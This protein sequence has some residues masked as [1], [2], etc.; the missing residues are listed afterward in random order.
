MGRQV[1]IFVVSIQE[2]DLLYAAL[3]KSSTMKHLLPLV[4]L[5][6]VSQALA[7]GTLR[8]SVL[9]EQTKEP[10][11]GA[12]VLLAGTGFN[13][14]AG[15]DG[16][17][18]IKNLPAAPY[19][20]TCQYLGY[21]SATQNV[22]INSQGV[23]NI[24]LALQEKKNQ[25]EEVVVT[26]VLNTESD[27][28]VRKL[29]QNASQVVNLVSARTIEVSPDLTV[30]NVIQRVS[31]V[32]IERNSNG[33]GQYAIL[34]G[35]DKRYNYTLVNGIKIP[36]PDNKYRYVPLDLFP[37][38][39][40]G[41]LEVYKSLTPDLEGDA[42]GGVVNIVMKDAPGEKMF[43]I[44]L[45][46]GY[47]ELFMNRPFV[48]FE[49]SGV[50][51]KSPYETGGGNAYYATP[52]DFPKGTISYKYQSPIP[53]LVGNISVGNRYFGNRLGVV[54]AAS[55]QNT[56]RGSNSAFFS[57]N[58]YDIE[59]TSRITSLSERQFSERQARLGLHSKIDFRLS[60]KSKFQWYN[61]LM[62][63]RNEQ[64]R[65][66]KETNFSSGYDTTAGHD[67][68]PNASLTYT[69][70]SRLTQQ[71]I[72]NSTLQ[73]THLFAEALK[74][75]WSAVYSK[76]TNYVP[77]NA[78]ASVFGVRKDFVETQT[79]PSGMTR[80]WDH[81]SDRDLAAYL[82]LTY[83]QDIGESHLELSVGGLYRDKY[84]D[85]FYNN[86]TFSPANA[87]AQYGKDYTNFSEI[88]W[89]LNNPQ[90]AV[91]SS[92]TYT[93]SEKTAAAYLMGKL[94]TA[95]L[96]LIGGL[97]AE[98]TD[99]GYQMRFPL[100]EKRPSGSQVYTD[101][102]PSLNLKYSPKE[103]TNLR[104]SYFRSLNRPGFAELVPGPRPPT[105]E[106]IERGN[107]DLKRAIADNLDLRY[108]L[109]P[110]RTDQFM[111][112]IFYKYL[113]DPIEFTLQP[114]DT[115]QQDI[116]YIPGNFG[117]ATNYGFELDFIKYIRN[118]GIKANYTFTQSSITTQK[119]IRIR[120]EKG[121][122]KTINTDQTRP[123]Y[124]QS[125]HIANLS[126]LYKDSKSGWD[127]QLAGSYTGERI[128]IVAQFK[129]NDLWQAPF[130]QVDASAEKKIGSHWVVF[131]KANN[132]LDNPLKVFI[133]G[134]NLKNNNIPEQDEATGQTLIRRDYYQRSYLL[135]I[136]YKL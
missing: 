110:T 89:A 105:E 40:I 47:N 79:T 134:T 115:R 119:S 2:Q 126:L 83:L 111:A 60:D 96:Q 23:V 56:Y 9:D 84:R 94:N 64:I 37:S 43:K 12:V 57:S 49:A 53:N 29:E 66:A 73:G 116:Y 92:Q 15:L 35:M 112:G 32:S 123:L 21:E 33:D 132:L 91:A 7:Q 88:S 93:A 87:Q 69:T 59:A 48:S 62:S 114:D 24:S 25:L 55:F 50:N 98:H 133:K 99:Q 36:S 102:L 19:S 46:G 3:E 109:F 122:Q 121:E 5:L 45:S 90:G 86:Y 104:A 51:F 44:N 11:I 4:F 118:F 120:D 26:G 81:N 30:A 113:Q 95:N 71:Q 130:V 129:D 22:I 74:F 42:V 61:A 97:R 31:G 54:V 18:V 101:L 82:N 39:L 117:N 1:F 78:S 136:R 70:R 131:A 76:A 13:A 67:P 52:R 27:A 16:S 8:G 10:L 72:F 125:Q 20:V 38:D 63:L 65:E 127:A 6:M 17:F 128:N 107:P 75:N 68:K 100:G 80:R 124:G 28:N 14:V 108:E 106:Y 77:D 41:R 85:N 135:G 34:R 58:V 103:N